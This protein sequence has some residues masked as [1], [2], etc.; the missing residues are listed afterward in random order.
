VCLVDNAGGRA[1]PSES[2]VSDP[3]LRQ[4]RTA[5]FMGMSTDPVIIVATDLF[6][7]E[8]RAFPESAS[9]AKTTPK[10][11]VHACSE[12]LADLERGRHPELGRL[13]GLGRMLG[14]RPPP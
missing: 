8:I 11:L 9:P 4:C 12:W 7:R 6:R 2:R 5:T 13:D 10:L 3:H 1:E 14:S